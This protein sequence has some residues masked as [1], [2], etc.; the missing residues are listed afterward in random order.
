MTVENDT[1]AIGSIHKLLL[2]ANPQKRDAVIQIYTI[3]HYTQNKT[4]H[5][6]LILELQKSL[7]APRVDD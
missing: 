1:N 7:E 4:V 5:L 6:R 3:L 2:L